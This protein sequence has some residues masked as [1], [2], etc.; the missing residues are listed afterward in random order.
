MEISE[1]EAIGWIKRHPNSERN[2]DTHI[3]FEF[4][5]PGFDYHI[6]SI[7]KGDDDQYDVSINCVPENTTFNEWSNSECHFYGF[8]KNIAELHF[9]MQC[10][11]VV[12]YKGYDKH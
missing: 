6:M 1:I 2:L 9:I 10:I 8:V 11:G 3:T 12:E 4:P 5:A 7:G